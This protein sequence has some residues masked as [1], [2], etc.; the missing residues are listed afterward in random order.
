MRCTRKLREGEGEV[1]AQN[2]IFLPELGEAE[3]AF[4]S[5]SCGFQ[6]QQFLLLLLSNTGDALAQALPSLPPFSPKTK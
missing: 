2:S 5:A 1:R 3:E 4:D 6:T